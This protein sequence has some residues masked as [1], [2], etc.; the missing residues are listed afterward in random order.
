[1]TTDTKRTRQPKSSLGLI[2]SP[3]IIAPPTTDHALSKDKANVA[4]V[5]WTYFWP[6]T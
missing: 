5:G 2:V 4:F 3:S 6:T 1:M